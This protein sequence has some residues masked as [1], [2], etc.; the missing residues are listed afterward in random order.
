MNK[1]VTNSSLKEVS[2]E[3]LLSY[4]V[5]EHFL[6]TPDHIPAHAEV[7]GGT[8]LCLDYVSLSVTLL[9]NLLSYMITGVVYYSLSKIRYGPL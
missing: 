3:K 6:T 9:M 2:G 5:P 4:Y 7:L 8:V 1:S